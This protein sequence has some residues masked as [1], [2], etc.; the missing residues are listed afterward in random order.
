[1]PGNSVRRAAKGVAG[2]LGSSAGLDDSTR[3][4]MRLTTRLVVVSTKR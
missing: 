4:I 2:F 3:D 1:M